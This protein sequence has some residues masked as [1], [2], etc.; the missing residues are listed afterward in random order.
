MIQQL[1]L[2]NIV[3]DSVDGIG[4][5][6]GKGGNLNNLADGGGI[7]LY[8]ITKEGKISYNFMHQDF[9]KSSAQDVLADSQS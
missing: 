3:D 4:C 1:N 5:P 7:I 2:W 8:L 9:M 6:D